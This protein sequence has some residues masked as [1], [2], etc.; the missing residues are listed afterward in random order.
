M[1]LEGAASE[2]A[3]KVAWLVKYKFPTLTSR[4]SPLHPYCFCLP[5]NSL[6]RDRFDMSRVHP[7]VGASLVVEQR[8]PPG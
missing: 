5:V 4:S 8:K 7:A 1:E 2:G 3:Q 6:Q